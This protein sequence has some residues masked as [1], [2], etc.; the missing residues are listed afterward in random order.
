MTA[1]TKI[2]F[3]GEYLSYSNAMI[4]EQLVLSVNEF[5]LTHCREQL[6]LIYAVE[7]PEGTYFAS[8]RGNSS[9]RDKNHLYSGFMQ[10]GYLIG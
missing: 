3:G 2:L 6:A 10:G 4:A 5:G 9:R 8:S 1:C 7:F